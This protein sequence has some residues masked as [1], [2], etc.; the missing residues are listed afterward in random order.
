MSETTPSKDHSDHV[1]PFCDEKSFDLPGLANHL[2]HYCPVF[3]EA[4]NDF[5]TEAWRNEK[6]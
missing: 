1:C 2:N 6:K 4:A 3:D 5:A